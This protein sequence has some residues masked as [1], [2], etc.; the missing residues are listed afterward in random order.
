MWK[1]NFQFL[2]LLL[3]KPRN[4]FVPKSLDR[5]MQLI[6]MAPY[7]YDLDRGEITNSDNFLKKA[8]SI[9]LC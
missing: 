6:S 2:T 7:I 3:T 9:V 1:D 4:T 5:L 8:H